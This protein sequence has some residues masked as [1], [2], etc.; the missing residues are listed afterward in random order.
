MESEIETVKASEVDPILEGLNPEQRAAVECTEGPV[1]IVAGAG[2]GKTRV[3]TTRIAWLIGKKEVAPE[4]ILALTF[5]KKAAGEMKERIAALVGERKARRIW[6]GTFH[7]IFVRFLREFADRLGYPAAF[8]IYDQSDSQ[9]AIKS[10]IRQLGLD[11]KNTYKPK[12]VQSRISMAKNGLYTAA[13]YAADEKLREADRLQKKPDLYRIFQLYE[14]TCRQSGVMDFDDLLLNM[15]ILLK[16]SPEIRDVIAGRFDYILVDEYQDTNLAQYR[17]LR[18]LAKDH[19]NICVVGDDSQSIYAFRGANIGNILGFQKDYP[20]SR[21]FRL[22]RNYRSTQMIVGAS[23]SLIARNEGRIPKVCRA[24]QGG[25][26]E[27]IRLVKAFDE[28]TEASLVVGNILSR[29]REEKAQYRD[30]AILYRTNAQSRALEEALRRRNLPYMIYSGNSFFERAE[31]K[32]MMAYLKIVVNPSD[33]ESFKRVVNKPARGIGETSLHALEEAGRSAGLSL[34]QAASLDNLESFGLRGAAVAKIRSFTAMILRL[35]ELAPV[36]DAHELVTRIADDSGLYLFYK[37][38]NSIEGQAR[39]ANV[40]EL[41]SSV[42]RFS[43][44]KKADRRADLLA[45]GKY[46]DETEIP[47]DAVGIVSLGDFLEDISL[48]SNAD[49]SAPDDDTNRIALMTAHAAKGLEFPHVIVV[50]MEENLFPSMSM[51]FRPQD[52]EEE[53]RLFYVA[54]TR[55]MKT[56]TF[57]YCESRMRNG[58]HESNSP[59]RFLREIDSQYVANPIRREDSFASG[60]FFSRAPWASQERDSE[61]DPAL[62]RK[63]R[64]LS[65]EVRFMP[66]RPA[67]SGL[68]KGVEV[69]EGLSTPA[70]LRKA[71]GAAPRHTIQSLKNRPLP[72]KIPDEEFQPVTMDKILPGGRVEHNRFGFGTVLDVTGRIPDLKARIRFDEYG[73]K[74][75]LLKFAKLRLA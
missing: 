72:E 70:P 63:Q 51:L 54:M 42:A 45:E 26:G 71:G 2:S 67:A 59:S 10:C 69:S 46:D 44:Q 40:E 65:S 53:R 25:E 49:T 73:E 11:E 14:T 22:E 29:M 1:L 55:A 35:H 74:I 41:V 68:R 39:T 18:Q 13:Y 24:A 30:F 60:G 43:A 4:R 6:M 52:I 33:D 3:L 58:R 5:T 47:E 50:G 27:K 62:D 7:S 17:I 20:E 8:T 32:D 64:E 15:N 34:L 28:A 31:V 56:V 75:L 61:R 9:S 23:N 48:L 37:S 19:H 16:G 38:D 12:E 57:T 36:T 21:V 66:R